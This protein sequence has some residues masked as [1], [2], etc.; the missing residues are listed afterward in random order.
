MEALLI[1][2]ES[3]CEEVVSIEDTAKFLS[4]MNSYSQNEILFLMPESRKCKNIKE[5]ERSIGVRAKKVEWL[6]LNPNGACKKTE[7][8][9]L[10]GIR[11]IA[12][13]SKGI[14][15]VIVYAGRREVLSVWVN[16]RNNRLYKCDLKKEQI[17]KGAVIR[18]P[19]TRSTPINIKKRKVIKR[20]F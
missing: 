1:P 20:I 7:S 18:V 8:Q 16:L 15:R 14:K 17:K 5:I 3:F 19:V 4:N 6:I 13:S 2:N 10:D 11:K 9:I 12:V